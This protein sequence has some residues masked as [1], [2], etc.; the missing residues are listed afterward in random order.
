MWVKADLHIH[1]NR[2][3][4][5]PSPRE[6]IHYAYYYRGLKI[7]SITDHD[8]FQGSIDAKKYVEN[9]N[10][11]LLLVIGNEVRTDN[12]DVLV[13]CMEP[14][15]TYR[16]IDKLLEK[17]HDNNCIVVP[18]HPFDK[19]R[20]G[21]GDLVYSYKWDAIEVWNPHASKGANRKA[22]EAAKKLDIAGL[23][24]SDAHILE[25]IGTAYTEIYVDNLDFE[26]FRKALEKKL[27]KPYFG[28]WNFRV[29]VKHTVHAV[30]TMLANRCRKHNVDFE[31]DT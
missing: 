16:S 11:E 22:L 10:G 29:L 13:Y 17:A 21:I 3:D 14:I 6:A 30:R 27:V 18:A 24:C 25:A 8:T 7:V 1:T 12:G 4:G 5:S 23:S 31:T 28:T 2:S 20:F 19:F 9:L 15:D 26:S